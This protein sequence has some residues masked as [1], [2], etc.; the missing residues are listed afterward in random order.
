M[1][2]A[3]RLLRAEVDVDAQVGGDVQEVEEGDLSSEI[4]IKRRLFG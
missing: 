3:V 1:K 4:C 2:G